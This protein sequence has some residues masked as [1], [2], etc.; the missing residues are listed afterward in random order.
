LAIEQDMGLNL[1]GGVYDWQISGREVAVVQKWAREETGISAAREAAANE[2]LAS[3]EFGGRFEA[4]MYQDWQ[5]DL[6][7]AWKRGGSLLTEQGS[8]AVELQVRFE[9]GSDV[10]VA[11]QAYSR[12]KEVGQ[13]GTAI[14]ADLEL[15]LP[16]PDEPAI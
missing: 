14:M 1:H 7:G 5:A 16:S 13:C 6:H 3:Y 15:S 12:G 2:A 4:V 8:A 9:E 11:V 10:P